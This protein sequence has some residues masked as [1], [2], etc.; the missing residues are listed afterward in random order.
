MT[1]PL[2]GTDRGSGLL[3]VSTIDLA[4]DVSNV[5]HINVSNGTLVDDGNGQVTITTGGGAAANITVKLSDNSVSVANV[6]TM[7]Y[8]ITDGFTLTNDGGGS[9]TV[10]MNSFWYEI[11]VTGQTTLIPSGQQDIQFVA[12]TNMTLTTDNTSN[13]VRITWNASNPTGVTGDKGLT[14]NTGLTG[15]TGNKGLTGLTGAQGDKG[16]SG[17][18]GLT[19]SKGLTGEQGDIGLTGAQGSA[20]GK[21]LTGLTGTIGLTGDIGLTGNTGLTG[22][23]G[24]TGA[25]GSVG[26]IG[27][28]GNTGLEGLTGLTGNTGVLQEMRGSV[29]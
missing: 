22:L 19:G 5:T 13:P 15:A 7:S 10:G 28:T 25:T 4:T 18:I 17:T 1:Y 16:D 2:T 3:R 24:L 20:G 12:G 27:L 14:G 8:D 9:V 26:E 29:V 23:T 21:G 6:N 11:S